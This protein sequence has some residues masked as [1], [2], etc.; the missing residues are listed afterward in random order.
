VARF[1]RL[2]VDE[3]FD[4]AYALWSPGMQSRYSQSGY[5]DGR[6]GP[7]TEIVLQRNEII[8]FDPAAGTA[9][10]AVDILE[11]RESGTSPR[12]FIGDWDLVL[13]DGRWRMHDPDF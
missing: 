13:I 7:T 12:R 10:V 9:T 4:D 5:V 8:A 1:Y 2:V 3:R 11:Y 6:F